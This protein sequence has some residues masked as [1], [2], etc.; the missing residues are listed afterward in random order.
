MLKGKNKAKQNIHYSPTP[1]RT[2]R[3]RD[4]RNFYRVFV[5]VKLTSPLA[6]GQYHIKISDVTTLMTN[7][8]MVMVF[9]ASHIGSCSTNQRQ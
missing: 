7:P 1:L 6:C 2:I 4:E 5:K 8:E 9:G 3:T